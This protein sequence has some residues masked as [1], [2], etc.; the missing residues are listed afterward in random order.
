MTSGKDLTFKAVT[1]FHRA[2]YDLSKGR[3]AGSGGGMPVVK[4]TTVGRKSGERRVTMLTTPLELG[5]N[6]ILVASYG[7]DDR[8]PAWY[9]NLVA[10]SDVDIQL[11]GQ[12]RSMR[13]RVADG[14]E[15]DRLWT[16]LTAA[17]A[18]YAGYQTKTTR[19]LPVVVLEPR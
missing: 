5:A 18:N 2:L 7:G 12:T 13:A 6:V 17:H 11:R 15:R 19:V 16:Q 10:H 8:H 9:G 4:L 3:I 14:E 1:R